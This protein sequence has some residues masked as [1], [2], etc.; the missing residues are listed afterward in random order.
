[1][2]AMRHMVP[3]LMALACCQSE[4][5]EK[6]QNEPV[7]RTE[8][9]KARLA[10]RQLDDAKAQYQSAIAAFDR[11]D[12]SEA[13]GLFERVKAFD[14][15]L[16]EFPGLGI[17]LTTARESL[18]N[19]EAEQQAAQ[20]ELVARYGAKPTR[21]VIKD[22]LGDNVKDPDSLDIVEL[23]T[24]SLTEQG[25]QATCRYR[26]KNSFGALVKESKTFTVLHGQVVKVVD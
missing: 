18:A 21:R 24:Y 4:P 1:M 26:A 14:P 12:V 15:E 8:A 9:V 3:L 16:K 5:L 25:W 23:S 13:V 22:W 7:V 19:Q 17:R 2:K 11:G 6:T 20:A 10:E